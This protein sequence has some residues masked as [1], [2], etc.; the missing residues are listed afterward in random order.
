[1]VGGMWNKANQTPFGSS[2]IGPTV[3]PSLFGT[4]EANGGPR[5]HNL[6]AAFGATVMGHVPPAPL[7]TKAPTV[8]G[9]VIG[10]LG[11]EPTPTKELGDIIAKFLDEVVDHLADKVAAKVM[12]QLAARDA[13]PEEAAL[14]P[15]FYRG[16]ADQMGLSE[17]KEFLATG[18]DDEAAWNAALNKKL[19]AEGAFWGQVGKANLLLQHALVSADLPLVR[20]APGPV[21]VRVSAGE[22][23]WEDHFYAGGMNAPMLCEQCPPDRYAWIRN[24]E[25]VHKDEWPS[26]P[27]EAYWTL[28]EILQKMGI[29]QKPAQ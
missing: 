20:Y 15:M 24:G 3:G 2:V 14:S 23:S 16:G 9:T 8:A 10:R 18:A 22:Q 26:V 28:D 29:S 12:A 17:F 25:A 19:E 6:G 13:K 21:S 4:V 7:H 1:M 27:A 11:A 5:I